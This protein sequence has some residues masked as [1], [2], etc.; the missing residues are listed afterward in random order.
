MPTRLQ[1]LIPIGIAA[2]IIGIAGVV[3]MPSEVKLEQVNFPTG[4]I[5]LD[6][7]FLEV[8]IAETAPEK[9]RG[10]MFQDM[11]PYDQG[12]LFVFEAP[13]KRSMWM[14][15]MQFSLDIIWFDKNGNVV[16]IKTNVPPCK[17]PLE[18]M[19]C[20]STPVSSDNAK[21]VL[22]VTSGFIDK[23]SIDSDSK[24]EIISI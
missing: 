21:Y 16:E 1:V 13:G 18:I 3:S 11:L 12:M 20:D 5:K 22:E 4:T 19:S 14:L 23:F 8:Q 6:D 17:T 10:L 7:K 2:V 24:L 15:N 9:A